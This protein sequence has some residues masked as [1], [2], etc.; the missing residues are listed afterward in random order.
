MKSIPNNYRHSAHIH[1]KNGIS[2]RREPSAGSFRKLSMN[3]HR[4]LSFHGRIPR[5]SFVS[6]TVRQRNAEDI[7]TVSQR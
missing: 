7:L 3:P 6:T 5:L 1:R 4:L 2:L